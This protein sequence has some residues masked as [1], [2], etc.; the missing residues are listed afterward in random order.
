MVGSEAF[1]NA[2]LRKLLAQTTQ[3]YD[4][5]ITDLRDSE[6]KY[7]MLAENSP[8]P[9]QVFS[10]DGRTLRVNQAW[11]RM[12]RTPF[13]AMEQYNLFQDQQLEENGT[14]ELLKKAFAGEAVEIPALH[15]D[16]GQTPEVPSDDGDLWVRAFAYPVHG[17][18]GVLRQVVV[19]QEDVTERVASE[20]QIHN[21]AYLDPLT[22]LPNRRLLMDRLSQALIAGNRSKEYGVLLILDLDN[23]KTLNDSKGHDS[24]DRLLIEV[25]RNLKESVREEDT[26]ARFGGDEFV[27]VLEGLGQNEG[28][29]AN[30]AEFIAEKIRHALAQTYVL[31]EGEV[32]HHSTPSIGLTLFLGQ[33]ES[34]EVLLK[35]ADVALYQAKGAGRNCIRFYSPAMQA[36]IDTNMAMVAELRKGLEKSEFQL[37]YQPQCDEQGRIFGFEALLRWT[38]PTRGM[39][40]PA[41]FI[42]LAEESGLILPIGQWVLDTACAQLKT[43][44]QDS[45]SR[46]LLLS[47]NVSARQFHQPD[48]VGRVEQRLKASGANPARLKLEL[49]ESVVLDNIE[50]VSGKMQQLD[51]LGVTFSMD[52]FGIGY[53]SLS[54]LNRPMPPEDLDAFL[55]D[56]V[57]R[58]C[59]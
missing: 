55:R 43:W 8:L 59:R 2:L 51:A 26:V 31:G 25:A 6:Q 9:I 27:V 42:P 24:G 7:R 21:L 35:Q 58:E 14:L 10:P 41:Q 1:E 38:S 40:S 3:A 52:D 18:D 5:M 57:I 32:E 23:F 33:G 19:I 28:S 22:Q 48:F 44:E 37:F 54:Y 36:V 4:E 46:E 34:V 16:K 20:E 47:V 56:P 49:T 15:Y 12:W 11:E 50:N 17:L 53:S 30:Q 45:N 29:A 39:V 13:A